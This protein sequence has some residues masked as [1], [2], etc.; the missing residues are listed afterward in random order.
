VISGKKT[1]TGKPFLCNDPHLGAASDRL[2]NVVVLVFPKHAE[3][4]C[5]RRFS[6]FLVRN[7]HRF[8]SI[9]YDSILGMLGHAVPSIWLLFDLRCPT[10]HA[11]GTALPSIPVYGF[12]FLFFFLF[13]VFV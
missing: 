5:V 1:R 3:N 10:F 13:F 7:V 11:I 2:M 6:H 9:R 12:F 8:D 4:C